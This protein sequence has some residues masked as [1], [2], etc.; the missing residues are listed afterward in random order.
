M[1]LNEP[2]TIADSALVPIA[3]LLSPLALATDPPSA[4]TPMARE[5]DPVIRVPAFFP[6]A[7]LLVS[8]VPDSAAIPMAMFPEPSCILLPD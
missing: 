6:M 5:L 8:A 1:V 4:L 3:M 2:E 7:M